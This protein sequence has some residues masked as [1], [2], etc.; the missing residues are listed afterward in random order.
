MVECTGQIPTERTLIHFVVCY[1]TVIL[2]LKS[3]NLQSMSRPP[4]YLPVRAAVRI[5]IPSYRNCPVISA[6]NLSLP[7]HTANR[8]N[9]FFCP[10]LQFY[11]V[12]TAP[13]YP[14]S[15]PD[16]KLESKWCNIVSSL[17]GCISSC[18]V[19]MS[20]GTPQL[21]ADN[22]QSLNWTIEQFEQF[23]HCQNSLRYKQFVIVGFK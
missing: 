1:F 14:D 4:L 8:A 6:N 23:E 22:L 19:C 7:S 3:R 15:Q 16:F 18:M 9:Y 10:P 17:A 5:Q 20:H 13:R 12:L 2:W 11:Q 21:E